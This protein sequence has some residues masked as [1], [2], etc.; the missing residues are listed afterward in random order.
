MKKLLII[1]LTC[2]LGAACSSNKQISYLRND[3]NLIN[4]NKI[5]EKYS[6][7]FAAYVTLIQLNEIG[8][9]SVAN[10]WAHDPIPAEIWIEWEDA[11]ATRFTP[12]SHL[13]LAAY[14]SYFLQKYKEDAKFAKA[15]L[16]KYRSDKLY[17][18]GAI[19]A[20]ALNSTHIEERNYGYFWLKEI[21]PKV[22]RFES[23]ASQSVRLKQIDNINE[24]L[25]SNTLQ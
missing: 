7:A 24:F 19:F 5:D 11:F 9:E 8:F 4:A 17:K 15:V 21:F 20:D 25:L 1:A 16:N 6:Q 10:A 2:S 23:D 13:I 12:T 14:N 22:P 3:L 18:T